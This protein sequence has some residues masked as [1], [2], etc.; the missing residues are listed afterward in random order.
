M[1]ALRLV[2]TSVEE[3]SRLAVK[4]AGET[5]GEDP[6]VLSIHCSAGGNL[7]VVMGKSFTSFDLVGVHDREPRVHRST[8]LTKTARYP[9]PAGPALLRLPHCYPKLPRLRDHSPDGLWSDLRAGGSRGRGFKSVTSPLSL[10]PSC[11]LDSNN[12]LIFENSVS[13]FC[14]PCRTG[15]LPLY[16]LL[17]MAIE[18]TT[19]GHFC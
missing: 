14:S 11:V 10:N 3:E 5:R 1:P 13:H 9:R 18:P 12:R 19:R 16:V 7:E 15:S 17:R 8:H 6:R 2:R 4:R